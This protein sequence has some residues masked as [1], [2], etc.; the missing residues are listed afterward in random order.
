MD[1]AGFV[2]GDGDRVVER[3]FTGLAE[4]LSDGDRVSGNGSFGFG[5]LSGRFPMGAVVSAAADEE[6]D[7]API[8]AGIFAGFAVG[9]KRS[10]RR[11]DDARDAI[12]GVAGFAGAEEVGFGEGGY[13]VDEG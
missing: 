12:E 8:G 1:E 5:K 9:E 4:F 13:G 3:D 2:V 6:I 10:F 7:F 11:D